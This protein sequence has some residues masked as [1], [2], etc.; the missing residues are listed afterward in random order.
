MKAIYRRSGESN[1]FLL[2][3]GILITGLLY[4]YRTGI[5]GNDFW[6][7]VKAGEWIIEHGQLMGVDA[8]SWFAGENGIKW[9]Q[10]EWLS[11]VLFYLIHH[12][13]GDIGIFWLSVFSALG[14]VLLITS[15]NRDKIKSNILLSILYLFPIV[16]LFPALLLRKAAAH[17]LLSAFCHAVLPVQIQRK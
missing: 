16:R 2:L 6:W 12:F 9:V 10:Q 4:A 14:M 3:M 1:M 13:S 11:Q 7:H 15:M 17:Q 8:F 5:S